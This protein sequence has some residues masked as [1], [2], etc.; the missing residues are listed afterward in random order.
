MKKEV[1]VD[2]IREAVVLDNVEST[3]PT[4]FVDKHTIL[5][6]ILVYYMTSLNT[7]S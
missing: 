7:A 4:L 1:Y 5:T 6:N 2:A 3:G